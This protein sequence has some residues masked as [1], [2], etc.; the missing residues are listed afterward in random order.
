MKTYLTPNAYVKNLHI[1]SLFRKSIFLVFAAIISLSAFST[2][3]PVELIFKN[4]T[5]K[6]G[7]AGQDGTV[8]RFAN[9]T[10]NV[11][12]F[13]KITGRST[14][15]VKL[16]S[17]DLTNTGWDKAWQPQVT[18]NNGSIDKAADWWME[19]E[20]SFW[21]TKNNTAAVIKNFDLTGLD[22]DGNGDRIHEYVSF[23]KQKSFTFE[24]HSLLGAT[25]CWADISGVNTPGKRFDGPF[26]NYQDIDPYASAV[27]VTNAYENLSSFRIRT[28]AIS[29][30]SNSATDRMYALWFKSFSYSNPI[31][32]LPVI[33]TSFDARFDQKK[34]TL[35]W[36]SSQEKNFSHYVI[37]KSFDGSEF[38]DVAIVFANGNTDTRSDYSYTDNVNT[39][40]K[41]VI[42]YRLKMVDID[43]NIRY[44]STRIIRIGDEKQQ[45]S[46]ITYPNPVTT[47]LRITIP[48]SWQNKTVSF[49]L[50]NT[51]GQIVKRSIS[52]RAGQTQVMMLNDIA[53]GIY[54]MK[55]SDGTETAIQRIVKSGK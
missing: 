3:T 33:L 38:N 26:R 34:A 9:V 28:G 20:I 15:K 43:K 23:F 36:A 4:A 10:A 52:N 46:I 14:S 32:V 48:S 42:Y 55:A 39:S 19:F 37:E 22:I 11:D 50:Y 6:E 35:N 40:S 12:A 29:T 24:N 25:N 45:L 44:S 30:G 47:E 2:E 27:M 7:V 49:D 41:G 16:E 8:Y 17:I 54:V 31:T 51:N 18:Y 21:D 53:N 5:I 1:I 13:V